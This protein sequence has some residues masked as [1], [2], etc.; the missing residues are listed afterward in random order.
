MEILVSVVM[1]AYNC[2]ASIGDSIES[3]L[4]QD[5]PLELIVVNDRSPDDLDAA[6]AKYLTDERVV[7]VTNEQNMGAALSLLLMALVFVCTG[8]I[9][10]FGG[11]EEGS[12]IV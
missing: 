2:A 3:V 8:I 11:D 9:N 7:Y 4:C 5:V 10:R 12:V 1:P 6:M